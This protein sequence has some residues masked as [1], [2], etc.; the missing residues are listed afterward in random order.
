MNAEE[1]RRLNAS[2]LLHEVYRQVRL[3]QNLSGAFREFVSN[4][5]PRLPLLTVG[6]FDIYP[7][8]AV[9]PWAPA[10]PPTPKP[11]HLEP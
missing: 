9:L 2:E 4:G 8:G 3:A 5:D 11:E 6:D 1:L 7:R 10:P